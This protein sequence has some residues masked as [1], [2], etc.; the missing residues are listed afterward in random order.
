MVLAALVVVLIT[1]IAAAILPA[2]GGCV[3]MMV[4]MMP[5]MGGGKSS[6]PERDSK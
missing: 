6:G 2:I 5:V 1:G 3:V 4:G